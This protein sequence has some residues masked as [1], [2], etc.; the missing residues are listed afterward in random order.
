MINLYSYPPMFG[1]PD[2]NPFGLKVDTFLRLAKIPYQ[3][4]YLLDANQAPRGQ[5]PCIED[6]GKLV[7]DSSQ[8]IH[9][10]SEKYKVLIDSQLIEAQKKLQ[11]L[12][13]RTLDDHLYW[14]ISYSR[15]QDEEYW[16]LFKA[17]FLRL[18]PKI[19]GDLDKAREYNI[20][21]YYYQ[22]I[23]RYERRD[24]Y[25][26]GIDDL[27][28][29]DSL[30]GDNPFLFGGEAHSIDA[31]CYGFLAPIVYFNIESPLKNFIIKETTLGQYTD[32]IRKL[33]DY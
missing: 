12:I 15:W 27:E 22:G 31:S 13:T 19:S 6:E 9:Y 21:K 10:L 32:R 1:L 4:E 30:L 14:V 17:E 2:N 7:S 24:I 25:Q 11:F 23:G 20:N 16:P 28:T 29:L 3:T 26:S 8:I 33:L 18:A 5:L